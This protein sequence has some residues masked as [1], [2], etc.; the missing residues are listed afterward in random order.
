M[1]GFLV[2]ALLFGKLGHARRLPRSDILPGTPRTIEPSYGAVEVKHAVIDRSLD[3]ARLLGEHLVASIDAR[4]TVEG[5]SFL[6]DVGSD[7][8]L[9][10]GAEQLVHEP[11][12][13]AGR[14]IAPRATEDDKLDLVTDMPHLLEGS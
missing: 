4:L 9:V 10:K 2:D 14:I 6:E 1:R 7:G 3:I 12:L 5:L 13:V 8:R 11:Y